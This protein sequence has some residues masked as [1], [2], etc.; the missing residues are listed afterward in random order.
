[1]KMR[2]E[3]DAPR[4]NTGNGRFVEYAD[5][6]TLIDLLDA[7]IEEHETA[8]LFRGHNPSPK[9]LAVKAER[10]KWRPNDGN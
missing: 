2:Y 8:C 5:V 1:M 3:C 7:W 4:F 9:A 6:V 10:D